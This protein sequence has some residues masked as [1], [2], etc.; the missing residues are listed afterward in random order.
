ML[1]GT[2][3]HTLDAKGR[4]IVPA[5]YRKSLGETFY[6][7]RNPDHCLAVYPEEAWNELREKMDT[8][9]KI[10]SEPARRLRRFYFG[11]S[12]LLES[13]KQGR[14][15]IPQP[16]REYAGLRKEVTLIGVDDHVEI[17]DRTLWEKENREN[18]LSDLALDL[19]GIRL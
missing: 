19:D 2:Y 6:M 18:D 13:D 5:D 16:L 7:T 14:I 9:P 3:N 17:W 15:L 1:M 8:L 12:V 4:L 11:N 10:S